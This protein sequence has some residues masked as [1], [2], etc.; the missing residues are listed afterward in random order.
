[1]KV[2]IV[3]ERSE[4]S[5]CIDGVPQFTLG[6]RTDVLDACPKAEGMLMAIRSLS[7]DI[8]VTDEIGRA[9]DRD[10]VLEAAHAGVAVISS[11]HASSLQEWR[12]RPYMNELF[13]AKAF[14]RYVLLSRRHGPGTVEM[15]LDEAGRP[16]F[17][18]TPDK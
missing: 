3:D 2:T 8:V 15:V 6:P 9:Q 12:L 4:L 14:S 11:A 7:P 18:T 5:G 16:L 17:G 10:A 13:E 1:M